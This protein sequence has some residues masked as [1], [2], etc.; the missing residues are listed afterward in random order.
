MINPK[1]VRVKDII[2]DSSHPEYVNED[3]IGVIYCCELDKYP[4]E[5]TKLLPKAKPLYNNISIFP[6]LEEIVYI[7]LGPTAEFDTIDSLTRYYL[8]PLNIHQTPTS[9]SLPVM[10]NEKFSF[11]EGEYFKNSSFVRPLR[12]YEGDVKIEG[13]FGNSIRLGS[14]INQEK[15]NHPNP[16]SNKGAVGNPITIIRNGQ[17]IDTEKNSFDHIIE[18][19]N[20]DHSSIYLCSRQ[21]ITNFIPASTHDESYLTKIFNTREQQEPLIT[22]TPITD[23]VKEDIVLSP[24]PSLPPEEFQDQ[25]INNIPTNQITTQYDDSG[26]ENQN[27]AEEDVIELENN[28]E[29]PDTIDMSILNERLNFEPPPAVQDNTIVAGFGGQGPNPFGGY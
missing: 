26:T 17:F 12:P 23:N 4:P 2:L 29:V 21:Q 25:E 11:K 13:R 5:Q 19:I 27:I 7:V 28:Y 6:V 1:L 16:W 24:T 10:L 20:N 22:N 18:D 3:S 14:T 15:V 9:N 8:P